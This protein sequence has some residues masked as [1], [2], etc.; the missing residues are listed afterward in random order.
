MSFGGRTYNE[1]R[2]GERLRAQ[3][4]RVWKLM[5]D[6][7]W[8]T[9]EGIARETGDPTTSVSARLRDFRKDKFGGHTVEREYMHDGLWKYRLRVRKR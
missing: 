8:R 9:L 4:N 2:D 1:S 6:G 5:H 3:F 7:T